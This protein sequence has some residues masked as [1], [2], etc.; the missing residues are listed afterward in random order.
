MRTDLILVNVGA[1]TGFM[2]GV[3]ISQQNGISKSVGYG[4]LGW[5][6]CFTVIEYLKNGKDF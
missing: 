5:I 6:V 1:I 4:L 2:A 3:L